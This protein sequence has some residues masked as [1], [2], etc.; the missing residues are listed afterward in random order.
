LLAVVPIAGAGGGDAVVVTVP[1][2]GAHASVDPMRTAA[3]ERE[4]RGMIGVWIIRALDE[5]SSNDGTRILTGD[6]TASTG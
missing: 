2:A 4:R 5:S 3:I 1:A 6:F